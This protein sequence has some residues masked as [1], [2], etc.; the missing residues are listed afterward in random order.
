MT[1]GRRS[2]FPS[3]QWYSTFTFW[4]STYDF[5]E[6]LAKPSQ[7]QTVGGRAA[8]DPNYWKGG[9]LCVCG[10]RPRSRAAEHAEKIATPHGP[11]SEAEAANL[12]HRYAMG[13]PLCITTKLAADVGDGS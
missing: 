6:A 13:M 4:P 11:S 8:N 10:E 1:D 7:S 9:L 3:N 12:A 5:V 2:Y